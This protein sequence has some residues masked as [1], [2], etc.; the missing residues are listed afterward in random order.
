MTKFL[1]RKLSLREWLHFFTLGIVTGIV[2]LAVHM[3]ISPAHAAGFYVGTYGGL[4]WDDVISHPKVSDHAGYVVGGVVGTRIDAVPGLRI[5]ADVSFR[6]NDVD[7]GPFGC[8]FKIVASHETFALLGNAVYDIPVKMGPVT[9][10]VL[11]GMGYANTSATFE[12]LSIAQLEASGFA[13]Q[14]GAGLNTR[15][16]E[17]VVLGVGYRYLQAPDI[18]V[19]GTQLSDGSNHAVVAEL[20]FAFP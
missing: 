5:E 17:T 16:A 15:L 20:K 2:V 6:Q 14:L 18:E 19:F 7:V 11:A 3:A 4:A 12:N 1:F 13:W 8:C 9:P 10:Y